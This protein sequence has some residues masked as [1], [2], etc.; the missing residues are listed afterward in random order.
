MEI[1]ILKEIEG[2]DLVSVEINHQ[3]KIIHK[4]DLEK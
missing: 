4:E 2:T 1:K 3:I